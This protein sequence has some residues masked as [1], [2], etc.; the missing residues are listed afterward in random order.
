MIVPI[1]ACLALVPFGP[2]DERLAGIACRSVHLAYEL[3]GADYAA[4]YNEL[5]PDRSA[6]GTYFCALGFNRGYFGLQELPNGKKL[7][8]FSIW[9]PGEQN[10]PTHVDESRRVKLLH[11]AEATRVGR[12]GGEGTG[13]QSFLDH[14]WQPGETYRF[15][16]RATVD[17]DRTA[18]AAYFRA[19]GDTSWT[20]MT[21]FSTPGGGE[22]LGGLYAFVEDFQRNRISLTRARVA[23]FANAWA[24]EPS[25]RWRSVSSARFTADSNPAANIDAGTRAGRFFLATGGDTKNDHAHLN[26]RIELDPAAEPPGELP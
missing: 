3:T 10:D 13:G 19:P 26:D 6:P 17:G 16:V 9:D 14:D 2:L 15:L 22:A 8:I 21:T 11:R 4:F 12:F 20:H 23:R 1:L 25:G 7:V 24:L 18:Y 5:T